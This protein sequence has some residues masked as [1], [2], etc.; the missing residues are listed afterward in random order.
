MVTV[1]PDHHLT[2]PA[3][4]DL[5]GHR[6][7]FIDLLA[8]DPGDAAVHVADAPAVGALHLAESALASAR[9]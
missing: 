6:A 5:E 3:H 7:D 4:D 9:R 8:P 2:S 1:G